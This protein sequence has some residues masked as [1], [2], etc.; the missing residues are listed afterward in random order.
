MTVLM[1]RHTLSANKQIKKGKQM[2]RLEV[3]AQRKSLANVLIESTL[4]LR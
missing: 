3:L 4:C 2:V 1:K